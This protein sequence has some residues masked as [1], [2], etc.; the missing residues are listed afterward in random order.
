M[1]SVESEGG[2]VSDTPR[3]DALIAEQEKRRAIYFPL[4]LDETIVLARQLERELGDGVRRTPA[5][6]PEEGFD[7]HHPSQDLA[8][9]VLTVES[10]WGVGG[11][12]P[13]TMYGEFAI[14]VA[15]RA[16]AANKPEHC[17]TCGWA[18]IK[19][20]DCCDR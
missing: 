8:A 2:S 18:R 11:L 16:L 7:S 13:E 5:V 1:G 6:K 3:V 12:G 9:I 20:T 4:R 10:E 19:R 14:E 15:K 17:E